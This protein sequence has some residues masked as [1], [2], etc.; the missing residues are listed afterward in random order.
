M[1]A[2]PG[3]HHSA[4][5]HPHH[6]AQD[7]IDRPSMSE[8]L[9]WLRAAA[10]QWSWQASMPRSRTMAR[11]SS[12]A[13]PRDGARREAGSTPGSGAELR[14][15]PEDGQPQGCFCCWAGGASPR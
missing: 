13:T 14:A 12:T 3:T 5:L 6:R 11:T 1:R 15:V 10:E 8:V 7:P 2:V 4:P 9:V